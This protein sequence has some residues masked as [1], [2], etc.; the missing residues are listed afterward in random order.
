VPKLKPLGMQH[1]TS[2]VYS[3]AVKTAVT[4]DQSKMTFYDYYFIKELV[5]INIRKS[6]IKP[7]MT[8]CLPTLGRCSQMRQFDQLRRAFNQAKQILMLN[9]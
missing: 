9:Q 3:I 6:Q 1:S 7:W 8:G 2:E 4:C 5:A